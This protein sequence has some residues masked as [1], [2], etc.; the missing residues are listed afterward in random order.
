MTS[1]EGIIKFNA[2]TAGGEKLIRLCQYVTKFLNAVLQ[3]YYRRYARGG[4]QLLE[5]IYKLGELEKYFISCRRLLS[6]GRCTDQFYSAVRSLQ[7]YDPVIRMTSSTSK[8][9]L[10][11]QMFADH[12]IWLDQIGCV[13]IQKKNWQERANKF[14]LYSISANLLRDFYELICIIQQKR[15]REKDNLESKVMNFTLST[16]I[17][18]ARNYPKLSCDLIKNSCE[19]WIPY[20]A[21]NKLNP[22]P[23]VLSMLGI[24]STT[25]GILQVYD[26]SY[27]LSPS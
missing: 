16:P 21:L 20:T 19:F 18:W 27:R 14:W 8:F 10:S 6:F 25:M 1:I 12:I 17:T 4:I 2:Q 13:Q 22:N 5:F 26:K 9:W 15:A 24:I 3:T 23:I 7:L 11:F